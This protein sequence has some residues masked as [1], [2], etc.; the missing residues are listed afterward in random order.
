MMFIRIKQK[1]LLYTNKLYLL[2]SKDGKKISFVCVFAWVHVSVGVH[3]NMF[4]C[5]VINIKNMFT[6]TH[7]CR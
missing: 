7:V 5:F 6:Y 4:S 1:F 2:S 3:V